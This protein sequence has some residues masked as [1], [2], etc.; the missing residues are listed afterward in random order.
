MNS[1][2][3]LAPVS[4]FFCCRFF[5]FIGTCSGFLLVSFFPLLVPV[6]GLFCCRSIFYWC[7]F[8]ISFGVVFFLIGACF[9]RLLH[10]PCMADSLPV[11]GTNARFFS[12]AFALI[13]GGDWTGQPLFIIIPR[14]KNRAKLLFF[15]EIC[16]IFCNLAPD[17]MKMCTLFVK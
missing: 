8:R 1:L 5:S 10:P 15:F 2:F 14:A 13:E 3:L 7:L 17:L 9:G 11:I 12:F 6:S 16:K 4:V